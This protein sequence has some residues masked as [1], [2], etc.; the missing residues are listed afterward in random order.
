MKI[1]VINFSG[2]VGKSTV[3]HHLLAP[4]L[5][6][7]EVISIESINSDG[8]ETAALRGKEFDELQERM[9]S[10]TN[11][12]VD[13]G[14]SN[15]EDYIALMQRYEGSHEDFDRF[16]VPTVPALKQQLD[17]I[18]TLNQLGELGIPS[19]KIRL[20]FNFVDGKA[21]VT[22]VF[23]RL[24]EQHRKTSAFVID[25]SAVVYENPIYEKIKSVGKTIREVNDDP[26]DYVAWNAQA[27]QDGSP[28]HERARIRQMVAIKRLASR[29]TREHDDAFRLLVH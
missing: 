16:V 2:N 28:E 11:V 27:L 21:N 1:A 18:A 23:A 15:V 4:R 29:V 7:A 12:V 8:T 24:F 20:L 26:I 17:T 19:S 5:E 14:A 13:V 6:G 22:K 9:M 3:A 25:S 10:R